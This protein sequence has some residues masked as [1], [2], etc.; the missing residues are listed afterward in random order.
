METEKPRLNPPLRGNANRSLNGQ[1]LGRRIRRFLSGRRSLGF[2]TTVWPYPSPSG[3]FTVTFGNI[4]IRVAGFTLIP[5]LD[6]LNL[7]S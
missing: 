7:V 6:G 4:L 3:G 2:P 1:F 5:L